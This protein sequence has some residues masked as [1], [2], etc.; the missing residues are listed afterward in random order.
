MFDYEDVRRMT[1]QERLRLRQVLAEFDAPDPAARR[2][3]QRRRTILLTLVIV[4]CV[5]LAAWIGLLAAT[6][7]RYYRAGDWRG[8]WVG[9]DIA[10][11][12]TFAATG[13]AAW[14]RRQILIICLVV[15]ATLLCCDAWF[16][17]VLDARTRGF[18][19]SLLSAILI[20]LPLAAVAIQGARRL[21]R[22]TNAVMQRNR[23]EAGPVPRLRD[24]PLAGVSPEH[25]LSD[26]LTEPEHHLPAGASTGSS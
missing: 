24:I 9:F 16:D 19:V 7:P 15:L 2:A 11:L 25:P 21:V 10:L 14:R 4:C 12:L 1:P 26:L 23:G 8:A 17:V 13:W 20:E 6:L 18:E 22:V 3:S 5:V